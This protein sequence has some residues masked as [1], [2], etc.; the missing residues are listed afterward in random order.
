[1]VFQ[2]TEHPK[3]YKY[4]AK[5][6]I[7]GV[8][9]F[10]EGMN[11]LLALDDFFGVIVEKKSSMAIKN[12]DEVEASFI[13]LVEWL[14]GS[15]LEL[16]KYCVGIAQVMPC[17]V[18]VEQQQEMVTTITREMYGCEGA[19]FFTTDEAM[20]W[21]SNTGRLHQKN[22]DKMFSNWVLN[23]FNFGWMQ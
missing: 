4:T 15:K 7:A 23:V 13:K 21:L 9:T 19:L 22:F 14:E 3:I 11:E 20:H 6:N 18:A 2:T 5:H 8:E 16:S 10:I 17:E 1:M 12:R